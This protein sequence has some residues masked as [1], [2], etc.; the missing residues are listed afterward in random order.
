MPVRFD[1]AE[2]TPHAVARWM[3]GPIVVLI[4][5]SLARQLPQAAAH[6][7]AAVRPDRPGVGH[8][9]RAGGDCTARTRYAERRSLNLHEY[10]QPASGAAP[11]RAYK[12]G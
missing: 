12:D 10:G 3:E 4:R 8:V 11:P 7:D 1:I 9:N 6:L 5:V 2:G